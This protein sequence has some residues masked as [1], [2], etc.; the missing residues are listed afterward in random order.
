[1]SNMTL[2]F[3]VV[4]HLIFQ[5]NSTAIPTTSTHDTH[6]A[7]IL[8]SFNFSDPGCKR[9]QNPDDKGFVK[10]IIVRNCSEANTTHSSSSRRS[11]SKTTYGR[12][13]YLQRLEI[14][15]NR[16]NFTKFYSTIQYLSVL[17]VLDV[18]A[19]ALTGSLPNIKECPHIQNLSFSNNNFSGTIPVSWTKLNEVVSIDISFNT[20]IEG[21]VPPN[22]WHLPSLKRLNVIGTQIRLENMNTSSVYVQNITNAG[23]FAVRSLV[24]NRTVYCNTSYEEQRG[25]F[26]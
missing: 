20:L 6:S 5:T 22:I 16:M 2:F 11:P 24:T 3:I 10:E 18:S 19:N 14:R 25:E 17:T 9:Y 4:I 15:N 21:P 8:D 23:Y 13:N 7:E 12:D 1:M 26:Q